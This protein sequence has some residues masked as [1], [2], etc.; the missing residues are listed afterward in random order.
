MVWIFNKVKESTSFMQPDEE[1]KTWQR[2]LKTGMLQLLSHPEKQWDILVFQYLGNLAVRTMKVFLFVFYSG[3]WFL[4]SWRQTIPWA[5]ITSRER[6][7]C[8]DRG[9]RDAR[10]NV[11]SLTSSSF[12]RSLRDASK[13]PKWGTGKGDKPNQAVLGLHFPVCALS[14]EDV[15][16]CSSF[17]LLQVQKLFRNTLS[18]C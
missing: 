1:I 17:E 2:P 11:N 13:K 15:K 14:W 12:S 18:K 4:S 8:W 10:T 5:L 16:F 9:C 6:S 3:I 7:F